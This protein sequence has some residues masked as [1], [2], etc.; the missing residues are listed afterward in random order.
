MTHQ[1]KLAFIRAKCIE[2]N[3]EIVEL[4]FGCLVRCMDYVGMEDTRRYAGVI[5][6]RENDCYVQKVIDSKEQLFTMDFRHEIIGRPIRLA[7]IILLLCN[8]KQEE[9]EFIEDYHLTE[10]LQRWNLRK[11]DLNEQDEAAISFLYDVLK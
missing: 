6:D 7:D 1:E 3:P 4:K 5:W 11:D 9:I 2:A 8:G 10:L